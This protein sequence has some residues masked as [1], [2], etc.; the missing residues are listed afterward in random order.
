M[1]W[2]SINFLDPDPPPRSRKKAPGYFDEYLPDSDKEEEQEDEVKGAK[3]SIA[4][5]FYGRISGSTRNSSALIPGNSSSRNPRRLC[6]SSNSAT[7]D[8]DALEEE[9]LPA[10]EK[11]RNSGETGHQIEVERKKDT[12]DSEETVAESEGE[13]EEGGGE[14]QMQAEVEQTTNPDEIEIAAQAHGKMNEAGDQRRVEK[15]KDSDENGSGENMIESG[16]YLAQPLTPLLFGL[17]LMHVP[18]AE[19]MAA[20]VP[21][22]LLNLTA[23]YLDDFS[24]LRGHEELQ[25]VIESLTQLRE[26][27][28]N[29]LRT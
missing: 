19:A 1:N 7:V 17:A 2:P 12:S 10:R 4:E 15:L 24:L 11:A 23:C 28:K 18:L 9:G 26:V 29:M 5:D 27:Y 22:N 20:V 13:A 14:M 3:R 6:A 8:I 16:H 25:S 21:N